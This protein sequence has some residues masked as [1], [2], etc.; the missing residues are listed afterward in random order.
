MLRAFP[1]GI[2]GAIRVPAH[3]VALGK[4][5][6]DKNEHAKFPE[7]QK[8]QQRSTSCSHLIAISI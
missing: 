8:A 5:M 4:L 1:A 6:S 3:S 7:F 2:H